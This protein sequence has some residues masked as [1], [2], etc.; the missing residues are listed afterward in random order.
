MARAIIISDPKRRPML[1]PL[2]AI[3]TETGATIEVFHCNRVLTRS[4]GTR[5]G[6]FHWS[7]ESGSRPQRSPIG[8]FNTAY[9]A[10]RHALRASVNG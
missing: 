8:P 4:F 5:T 2:C 1:E 6:W 9:S 7:R 3:D 10:L